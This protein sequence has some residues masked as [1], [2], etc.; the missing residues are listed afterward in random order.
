M[1]PDTRHSITARTPLVMALYL[2]P[3]A[4]KPPAAG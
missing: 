1:A 3:A 2:L 4:T